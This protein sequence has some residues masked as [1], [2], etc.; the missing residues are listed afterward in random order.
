G[1]VRVAASQ[2]W[3][4]ARAAGQADRLNFSSWPLPAARLPRLNVRS[5][6]FMGILPLSKL[7]TLH[8]RHQTHAAALHHHYSMTT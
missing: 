5:R 1:T 2:G 7:H 6:L 8:T 3:R 4:S